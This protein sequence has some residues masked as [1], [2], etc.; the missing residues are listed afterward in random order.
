[1][2]AF[3]QL[4]HPPLPK[5]SAV[6]RQAAGRLDVLVCDACVDASRFS[7]PAVAG[8]GQVLLA[9]WPSPYGRL[10]WSAW[11]SFGTGPFAVHAHGQRV[12]F[13]LCGMLLRVSDRDVTLVLR[14]NAVSQF[15]ATLLHSPWGNEWYST[16][17]EA[18]RVLGKLTHALAMLASPKLGDGYIFSG[19]HNYVI[20]DIPYSLKRAMDTVFFTSE[21]ERLKGTRAAAPTSQHAHL[22]GE[23]SIDEDEDEDGSGS[24]VQKAKR[25]RAQQDVA[26]DPV[27]LH[28]AVGPCCC[29]S[30]VARDRFKL[31]S[32]VDGNVQVARSGRIFGV[33]NGMCDLLL[34]CV[35]F[36]FFF[37]LF[38]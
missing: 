32:T 17:S 24:T 15:Q 7:L 36:W 34:L 31:S 4:T 1:M 2:R 33:V 28:D 14:S 3:I 20:L 13:A 27:V 10:F 26:E 11:D 18:V 16:A 6:A 30:A 38:L 5:E 9:H 21:G 35:L 12:H 29:C 19:L 25:E 23:E 8:Q 22:S 37:V